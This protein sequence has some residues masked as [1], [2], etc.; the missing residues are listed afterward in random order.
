MEELLTSSNLIMAL[1]PATGVFL[2]SIYFIR[3]FV[4]YQKDV[5][6]GL[7]D[8]MKEDRKL[9]KEEL[10]EFKNAVNKIDARLH[11]IEKT[12]DKN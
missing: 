7:V 4:G 2:L 1:G 3:T 11:Y 9:Q 12:L 6:M 5:M 8:E 10:E